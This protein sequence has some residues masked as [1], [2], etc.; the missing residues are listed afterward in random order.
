MTR[1]TD[2]SL[3]ADVPVSGQALPPLAVALAM[4][5][6]HLNIPLD[7]T[8]CVLTAAAG[9]LGTLAPFAIAPASPHAHRNAILGGSAS[10]LAVIGS[11]AAF[12][13]QAGLG[14]MLPAEA[15]G[16]GLVGIGSVVCAVTV[17]YVLARIGVA[18]KARQAAG[19]GV[20]EL[21]ASALLPDLRKVFRD[22]IVARAGA[23]G[24]LVKVRPDKE[25]VAMTREEF[26]RFEAALAPGMGD[27]VR[28]EPVGRRG[29]VPVFAMTYRSRGELANGP[30]DFPAM[31]A[32]DAAGRVGEKFMLLDVL[33]TVGLFSTECGLNS[34]VGRDLAAGGVL[35]REQESSWYVYDLAAGGRDLATES[36]AGLETA[37][38]QNGVPFVK[39]ETGRME[40]AYRTI[41]VSRNNGAGEP[42]PFDF[43]VGDCLPAWEAGS[44]VSVRTMSVRHAEAEPEPACA[45]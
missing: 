5:E 8:A 37:C 9:L 21:R 40:G 10:A 20:P 42:E 13:H 23:D 31:M 4:L 30:G 33:R 1:G 41:E 26:A 16:S 17:S 19:I 35:A 12:G 3:E 6:Q 28:I 44:P 18:V 11:I 24:W 22:V 34:S 39:L 45:M 15:A 27:L 36:L 7:P 38:A 14:S 25:P 32:F 29:G 43:G 2:G